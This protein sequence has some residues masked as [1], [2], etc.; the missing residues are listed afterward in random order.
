MRW[1]ELL[2]VLSNTKRKAPGN[3][4]IF[5][6]QIKD[7]HASSLAAI[8]DLYNEIWRSGD[9]PEIWKKAILVPIPKK[10]KAA[11]DPLSYRPISLLPIMGKVLESLVHPRLERY[12]L[13]RKLIPDF[14]T[15]FRKGHSTSINLR[16]LFSNTYFEST[17]G[18]CKR[19]TVSVF[20]DA[21]KSL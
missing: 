6:N 18:V 14:Q 15:G 13:E 17:I 16:R 7:L 21:K 12:L 3:D 9:F 1:G 2:R 5:I 4:G 10:G 11:G 19:P 8:L 20:F